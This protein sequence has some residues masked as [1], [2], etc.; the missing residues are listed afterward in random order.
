MRHLLSDLPYHLFLPLTAS[1]LFV[2]GLIFVKRTTSAGINP[3][4]VAFLS[5][6]WAAVVFSG[7]WFVGGT[8]Q[9]LSMIWQP[10]IIAFLYVAGLTFTFLA[11]E[12]GD[13]SVATPVFGVKVLFVAGLVT[14]FGGTSLS[15]TI[16]LAAALAVAGIGLIQWTGP[17]GQHR[18]LI[19]TILL[20]LSAAMSFATFDLLVQKWAPS[21]GVG[22]F[23]PL[24]YWLVALFSLVYLPRFQ[25]F[26]LRDP[27]LRKPLLAGACFVGLQAI[28]IVTTLSIFGD[29]TRV[30]IVYATRGLWG[31]L[32]AWGV[33]RIWGGAEAHVSSRI[34]LV[35]LAGAALLTMAVMLALLA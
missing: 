10:A 22:R 12:R 1:L 26:A 4:T 25:W 5:N 29:A 30:N 28:F 31:V 9:P 18:Q 8:G 21:W 2:V 7:F 3:W 15:T 23:L 34:M 24:I 13:V 11:I 35:R 6:L 19:L 33:A 27:R 16:W 20:A 17:G 14:I 32:F